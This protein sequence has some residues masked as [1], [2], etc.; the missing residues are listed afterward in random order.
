VRPLT[1]YEIASR[2]SYFLWSSLP[3]AELLHH[4]ALGDLQRPDVLLAQTRRMLKDE[5]V[6]DFATEFAGNWLDFRRFENFNSSTAS[7]SR[8]SPT[9]CARPCSGAGALPG[10]YDSYNRPVLD[11]LYGDYTFVNPVLANI[12]ACRR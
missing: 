2:L 3:D 1:S 9:N 7:A 8:R 12:T 11:M 10:R 6:R 5:R 4:A